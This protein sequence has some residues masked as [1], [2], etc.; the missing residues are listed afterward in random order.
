MRSELAEIR[1]RYA[2][3]LTADI[4]ALASNRF[5]RTRLARFVLTMFE[6]IGQER[7]FSGAGQAVPNLPGGSSDRARLFKRDLAAFLDRHQDDLARLEPHWNGRIDDDT[8]RARSLMGNLTAEI[9]ALAM[10]IAEA[11]GTPVR[12]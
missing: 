10:T 8:S 12:N 5:E 6:R 7:W 1:D 2:P 9:S 11:I 4:A 3:T